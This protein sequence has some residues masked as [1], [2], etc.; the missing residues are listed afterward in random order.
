[1]FVTLLAGVLA[2]AAPAMQ[3]DTTFAVD[4]GGRLRL[5]NL[6]GDVVVRS[7]SRSEVRISTPGDDEA[8]GLRIRRTG[9]LVQ[10]EAE[11][12]GDG[13]D[14]Y[15]VTIPAA[16]GVGVAGN[17]ID[18]TLDGVGGDVTVETVSGDVHVRG[19]KGNVEI[20]T[21]QGDVQLEDAS[22]RIGVHTANGDLTL[23]RID[24]DILAETIS[25]DVELSGITSSSVD[26]STVSGDVGYDG[27]IR[28]AGRYSLKSHSGDVTVTVPPDASAVVGAS[29]FSGE[30]DTDI[31]VQVTDTG[32]GKK[33]SFTLGSGAARL[34]LQS[35]SG[36][37]RLRRSAAGAG[38]H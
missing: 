12:P 23:S 13:A 6:R 26:A 24:G 38:T 3:S 4:P 34:E 16:M 31:P 36:D 29:T 19:G 21:V 8:R 14:R 11:E 22:G 5:E 1:M 15:E 18:V 17:N 10:V 30:L 7:W 25:G 20:H 37:I 28:D 35:F 9:P 32:P 27:T 33:I 2:L